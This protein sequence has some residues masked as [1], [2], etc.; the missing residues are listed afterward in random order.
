MFLPSVIPCD[1][2]VLCGIFR[3]GIYLLIICDL[4]DCDMIIVCD[5]YDCEMIFICDL[6]DCDIYLLI[7]GDLFSCLLSHFI[8]LLSCLSS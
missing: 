1:L 3:N 2:N 4:Y 5:L 7:F 6:Y 8:T